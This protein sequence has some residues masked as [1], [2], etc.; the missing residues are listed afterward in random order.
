MQLS[1]ILTYSVMRGAGQWCRSV[2]SIGG[3]NHPN[4]PFFVKF[5]LKVNIF[6]GKM[7]AAGG[8]FL[9]FYCFWQILSTFQQSDTKFG[10]LF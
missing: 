2:F 3:N 9:K 7:P 10:Y 1:E 8:K 5:P 4:F 6:V